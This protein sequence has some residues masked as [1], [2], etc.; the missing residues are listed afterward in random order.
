M[1]LSTQDCRS[2]SSKSVREADRHNNMATERHK[3]AERKKPELMS[4]AEMDKELADIKREMEELEMKMWQNKKPRWVYEWPMQKPKAKW[5]VRELMVKRQCRLLRKWLRYAENL[6]ATEEEMIDHCWPETGKGLDDWD[7]EEDKLGSSEDIIDCQE[8][9]GR[10]PYG[11][12][13][14]GTEMRSTEDLKNC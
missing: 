11:Q 8:R 12:V 6:K 3:H 14:K 9:N 7:D 5:P 10:F 13:G 2:D 4:A 1:K